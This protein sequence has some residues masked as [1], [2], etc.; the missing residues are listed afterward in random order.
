[1]EDTIGSQNALRRTD[2]QPCIRHSGEG[3]RCRD[4][5]KRADGS[6]GTVYLVKPISLQNRPMKCY[7]ITRW[8]AT[9]SPVCLVVSKKCSII[10]WK[11]Y[12]INKKNIIFAWELKGENKNERIWL[13]VI[14]LRCRYFFLILPPKGI[15]TICIVWKRNDWSGC[16]W[17]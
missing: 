1:M 5:P 9:K 7:K 16:Q 15:N 11:H 3:L 10:F 6:L 13:W 4:K 8:N 17:A 14:S 12:V 2:L